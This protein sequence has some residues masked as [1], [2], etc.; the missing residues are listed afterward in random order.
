[1]AGTAFDAKGADVPVAAVGKL[2]QPVER[3]LAKDDA[4]FAFA[5]LERIEIARGHQQIVIVARAVRHPVQRLDIGLAASGVALHPQNAVADEVLGDVDTGF[6]I[7]LLDNRRETA[8][9]IVVEAIFQLAVG[10]EDRIERGPV[11]PV[12]RV[13]VAIDQVADFLAGDQFVQLVR[14]AKCRHCDCSPVQRRHE[15]RDFIQ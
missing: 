5:L 14:A 11:A 8:C 10:P 6:G 7:D 4:P 13:A 12:D 2:A 15:R 3:H 9:S 1:M